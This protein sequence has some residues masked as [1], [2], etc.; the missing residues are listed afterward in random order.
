[1][2]PEVGHVRSDPG[3]IEQ[4][5]MN[6]TVNARD[7]MPTGGT[8]AINTANATLEDAFTRD[9]VGC[10]PGGYVMI[11]VTDA[12]IGMSPDTLSRVFEPFFTTKEQGKGTGLGLSTVYGIVKQSGGCVVAESELGRGTAF[13]VYLP[14]V[15]EPLDLED[16][17]AAEPA[18][19]RGT[20]CVLL[21]EDDNAVRALARAVLEQQGY[22]VIEAADPLEAIELAQ[23]YESTIDLV[24]TDVIMPRMSG[25]DL[26]ARVT[27]VRPGVRVLYMSGYARHLMTNQGVLEAGVEFLEKPFAPQALA[28]KVREVLDKSLTTTA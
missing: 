26:A 23:S 14:R 25:R 19:Y 12:G 10:E 27:E 6:L 3:Q 17:R 7:A 22:T 20:E 28:F 2:D 15:N 21:V 4:I 9:H 13:R 8:L 24:L 18:Y 1:L 11:S 16:P 5:L